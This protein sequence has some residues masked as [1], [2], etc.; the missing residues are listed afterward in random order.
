MKLIFLDV[1]GV[2][3]DN[4]TRTLT[5]DGWC[6]VDDEKVSNLAKIVKATGAEIVLSSSWRNDWHREDE[7]LNSLAFEDLRNKLREFGLTLMSKTGDWSLSRGRE[8]Q[9]WLDKWNGEPVENFLIID[10]WDDMAPI[11]GHFLKTDPA[12]GLDAGCV[13]EAISFLNN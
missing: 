7:S 6:F 3:N 12:R 5:R 10:D 2:L 11:H 9:E 4:D 13:K 1:D 8:I